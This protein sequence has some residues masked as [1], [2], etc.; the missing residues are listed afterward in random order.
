ML[1]VADS[2]S[3][4]TDWKLLLP[5]GDTQSF[6]T[7]GINPIFSTEKEIFR[8]L[9]HQNKFAPFASKIK[10]IF[11]FGAGCNS[12]DRREFVSNA[13]TSKFVNAFVSVET[14]LTGAAY[15]TCGNLPGLNCIIGTESNISFFD[16]NE[17]KEI[18]SGLGYILG[19]EASGTYFGKKLITD[20]LY[21][22][23]P[24]NLAAAFQKIY[25]INKE[26][27]IKNIYQKPLANYY[28]ASFAMFMSAFED[29]P[30][31]QDILTNSFTDY[32][33]NN[34][35]IYPNFK[36]Y[37]THFV[38]SIAFNFKNSLLKVCEQYEVNVGYI[39]EKPINQLF[40]FIKNREEF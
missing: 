21:K 12:P 3:S 19:D 34:I 7:A 9:S 39:L 28:L 8:I 5:I 14:D 18:N 20:F 24:I 40:D 35:V 33:L 6:E 29:D 38:G 37:K 32:V 13:L 15:A 22:K 11:F 1:L 25:Q 31:I 4:K 16:G 2:G 27:I 30:Y 10:E 17:V 26:T 23:M 36:Q